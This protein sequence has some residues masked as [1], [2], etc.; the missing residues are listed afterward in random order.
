MLEDSRLLQFAFHSSSS[1]MFKDCLP[2][3]IP[4]GVVCCDLGKVF[5]SCDDVRLCYNQMYVGF[6]DV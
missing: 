5:C 3:S 4:V 1:V 6:Q 2:V